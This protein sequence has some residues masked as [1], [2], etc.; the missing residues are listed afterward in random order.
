MVPSFELPFAICDVTNVE[1]YTRFKDVLMSMR[2]GVKLSADVFLPWTTT[3]DGVKA[4]VLA[5]MA[6]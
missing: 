4:L 6:P 1:G 3:R 5:S 2:D